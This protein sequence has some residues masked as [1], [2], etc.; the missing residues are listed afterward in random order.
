MADAERLVRAG[1]LPPEVGARAEAELHLAMARAHRARMRGRPSPAAWDRLADGMDRPPHPVPRRQGAL[2]AGAGAAAP[3][4]PPRG[5]PGGD[6]GRV[7]PG[8]RPARAAAAPD[9][10]GSRGARAAATPRRAG[11]RRGAGEPAGRAAPAA[12]DGP[13]TAGPTP[14]PAAGSWPSRWSA[15]AVRGA[16]AGRRSG[17]PRA[18]HP[19]RPPRTTDGVADAH[20]A[21]GST[22]TARAPR[23]WAS[24]RARWR[25]CASSARVAPT[26]RSP[27]ACTSPSARC[28]STCGACWPSW[29]SRRRTQAA[30]L[31]LRQG[32]VPIADAA[33]RDRL[34]RRPAAGAG[35]PHTDR[36]FMP[37]NR[38]HEDLPASGAWRRPR[39]GRRG[40][41]RPQR[42]ALDPAPG[43]LGR[44]RDRGPGQRRP[45]DR[46]ERRPVRRGER[47]PVRRRQRRPRP[48]PRR[49]AP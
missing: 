43:R 17:R 33:A 22:W 31:A 40:L 29:A 1:E 21:C 28:T 49:P 20:H 27:S 16:S 25:C 19:T 10:L 9:A 14:R 23:R 44:P 18:R 12:R 38:A 35:F 4:R 8:R 13:G 6:G 3:Q 37:Q 30:A 5:C 48:S 32:L 47:R 45:L 7:A 41:R 26:A 24:R 34:N 39:P 42:P 2:V 36:R 15:P 11:A 46:C